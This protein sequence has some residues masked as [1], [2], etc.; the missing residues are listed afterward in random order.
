[1]TS[2]LRASSG[3]EAGS[4][5]R[6]EPT[7]R[8]TRSCTRHRPEGDAGRR[9]EPRA[10]EVE[11]A[12]LEAAVG[13]EAPH[14]PV[15]RALDV[16]AM[17]RP[18]PALARPLGEEGEEGVLDAAA[19]HAAAQ[20]ERVDLGRAVGEAENREAGD[21]AVAEAVRERER[22]RLGRGI[23]DERLEL[24]DGVAPRRQVE[25]VRPLRELRRPGERA[26]VD[27]LDDDLLPELGEEVVVGR[28][29]AA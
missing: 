20:E 21:A 28:D 19:E 13:V 9:L 15:P 14:L 10:L 8:F 22:V 6:T 3:M 4:T 27:R 24:R 17:K 7:T 25:L 29:R 26:L 5:R 1:A 16:A 2:S 11:A 18:R 12:V 23:G